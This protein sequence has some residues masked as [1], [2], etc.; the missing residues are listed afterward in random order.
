[1]CLHHCYSM[2]ELPPVRRDPSDMRY[3]KVNDRL[4]AK[5]MSDKV[6]PTRRTTCPRE[7]VVGLRCDTK[8]VQR[9]RKVTT[10]ITTIG[11]N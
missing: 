1:M 2:T 5:A 9:L 7:C 3:V 6:K 10:T 8:C 4:M 11:D